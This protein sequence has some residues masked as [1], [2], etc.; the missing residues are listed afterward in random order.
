MTLLTN[1][2]TRERPDYLWLLPWAQLTHLDLPN[3]IIPIRTLHVILDQCICLR[4]TTLVVGHNTPPYFPDKETIVPKLE[5]L[6][7]YRFGPSPD[8]DTFLHPLVLPSLQ[9]L[10]VP[11]A[12]TW[13]QAAFTSFVIRSSCLL[14]SLHLAYYRHATHDLYSLAKELPS[15]NRLILPWLHISSS[16]FEAIHRREIFPALEHMECIVDTSGLNVLL[17]M[18]EQH[19]SENSRVHESTLR[20]RSG[21]FVCNDGDDVIDVMS[22]Y[23][24]LRPKF[25]DNGRDI[26]VFMGI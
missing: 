25:R 5:S 11:D 10:M 6:V 12:Q 17:D 22:R 24:D 13:N 2:S 4:T 26:R 19:I 9:L 3:S 21:T 23:R 16:I 15:L 18:V 1:G 8:W 20:I 14:K 7:L